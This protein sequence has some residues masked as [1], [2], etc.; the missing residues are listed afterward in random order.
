M[1][2]VTCIGRLDHNFWSK[3]WRSP[4]FI[5]WEILTPRSERREARTTAWPISNHWHS[6]GFSHPFS[7]FEIILIMFLCLDAYYIMVHTLQCMTFFHNGTSDLFSRFWRCHFPSLAW[8]KLQRGVKTLAKI[9]VSWHGCF[10]TI[11]R[12]FLLSS[13]VGNFGTLRRP[14]ILPWLQSSWCSPLCLPQPCPN[15]AVHCLNW[16]IE[17]M[18]LSTGLSGTVRIPKENLHLLSVTIHIAIYYLLN[19]LKLGI[20]ALALL[21]ESW[22]PR[23]QLY[24][25]LLPWHHEKE[26]AELFLAAWQGRMPH[27]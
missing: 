14:L 3:A 9:R 4:W 19:L 26:P 20:L 17:A 5:G 16:F 2:F 22:G 13:L 15:S 18:V 24:L 27:W 10:R 25:S 1:I 7:V 12:V 21:A 23:H 6:C 8:S 11:T